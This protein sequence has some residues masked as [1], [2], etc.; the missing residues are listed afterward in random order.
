[1]DKE[2]LAEH[3]KLCKKNLNA[4]KIRCCDKCPFEAE[5]CEAYPEMVE[6]FA[7]K[8]RYMYGHGV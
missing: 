4:V 8:R 3:V 2:K 6:K 1:M 7:N 5:I